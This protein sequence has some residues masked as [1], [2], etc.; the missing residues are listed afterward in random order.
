MRLVEEEDHLGLVEVA[1]LGQVLKQLGEHP[2]QEGR[3]DRGAL[4][5][6]LAGEDVDVAAAVFVGVHPIH[7]VELRLAEELLAALGLKGQQRA[8]DGADARGGDV[9]VLHGELGPVLAHELQHGAQVLQVEQ[10]QAVVV[11]H[12]EDDVQHA[13]LDLG[14]AEQTGQQRRAHGADRDAHWPTS[15]KM[16]QKRVG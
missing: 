12:A 14:Q 2:E 16:S 1:D 8:L 7:D 11:R 13:G 15:P 10:Q 3:V 4:D 6:L 5:Q 9:A